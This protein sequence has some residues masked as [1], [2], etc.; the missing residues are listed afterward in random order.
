MLPRHVSPLYPPSGHIASISSPRSL[1]AC[2]L[3]GGGIATPILRISAVPAFAAPSVSVRQKLRYA[4]G[5]FLLQPR[6][7]LSNAEVDTVK[8]NGRKPISK[9]YG[10]NVRVLEFRAN[11]DSGANATTL[12]RSGYRLPAIRMTA[13]KAAED[14]PLGA[15]GTAA[16]RRDCEAVSDLLGQVEGEISLARADGV[17]A[18]QGCHGA[19]AEQQACATTPPNDSAV[20]MRTAIPATRPSTTWTPTGVTAARTIAAIAPRVQRHRKRMISGLSL[21]AVMKIRAELGPDLSRLATVTHFCSWLGL[22]PDTKT[23]GARS[24]PPRP[25]AQP[26]GCARR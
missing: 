9:R 17:Y 10:I 22:C 11:A 23:S 13:D 26:T 6:A 14:N 18:T 4:P 12:G 25:S 2:L 19:I 1:A 3:I 21:T 7:G 20:T 5:Q 24:S 15:A 16:N 8:P